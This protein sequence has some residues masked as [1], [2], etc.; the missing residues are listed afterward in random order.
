MVILCFSQRREGAK[1]WLGSCF[2][3]QRAGDAERVEESF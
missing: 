1:G 2:F 3:T